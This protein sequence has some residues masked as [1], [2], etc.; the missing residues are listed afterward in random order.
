MSSRH[1]ASASSCTWRRDP[2]ADPNTHP[3]QQG[4]P[5]A[6]AGC[7]AHAVIPSPPESSQVAEV[8]AAFRKVITHTTEHWGS[9]R[10]DWFQN[11]QRGIAV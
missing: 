1:S 11:K 3:T 9:R 5:P 8:D 7:R 6:E 10:Y 4:W 2:L